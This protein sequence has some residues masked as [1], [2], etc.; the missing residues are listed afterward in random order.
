MKTTIL[1]SFRLVLCALFVLAWGSPA[2]TAED[3]KLRFG[4]SFPSERSAEALDGRMLLL[5]STDDS[6]EPR[7]QISDSAQTQLIFGVD[8]D[9]LNPDDDA[10]IDAGVLGYPLNSIGE[11][12]AGEY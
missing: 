7:F 9:G 10:H 2:E 4:L 6:N 5:I 11:I 1:H 3:A 12:P 8:V